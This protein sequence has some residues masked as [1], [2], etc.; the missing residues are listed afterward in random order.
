MVPLGN[1]PR[2]AGNG[3]MAFADAWR[4]VVVADFRGPLAT[5]DAGANW[6][7]L[8]LNKPV[9][10]LSVDGD[11]IVI[12]IQSKSFTLDAT[13][14]V[15]PY[16]PSSGKALAKD[17]S[18]GRSIG[19]HALRMA[20]D[21]GVP[22]AKDRALVAF[23]GKLIEV[24]TTDGTVVRV[25]KDVYPER[26]SKCQGIPLG[27]GVGF[28]CGA[29]QGSTVV[30]QYEPPDFLRPVLSYPEPKVVLSS[31]N[32]AIVVR[33]PCPKGKPIAYQSQYCVRSV[34]G[35]HREVRFQGDLG[36]ER[37]VALADGRVAVLIAPRPGAEARL[38]LLDGSQASA[39]TLSFDSLSKR[40]RALAEQGLWM[41][42]VIEVEPGVLGVWVEA[43]GPVLGMHIDLE[44]N[45]KAGPLQTTPGV[46]LLSGRLGLVWRRG[47]GWETTDGGLRWRE[48][49]APFS[50]RKK[51]NGRRGCSAIGCAVEGWLR[52]GWGKPKNKDEFKEAP[53]SKVARPAYHPPQRLRFQCAATGQTSAPPLPIPKTQIVQ[54]HVRPP[55]RI[56]A[57]QGWY[58]FGSSP[59][60]TLSADQVGVSSGRDYGGLMFRTYAWGPKAADWSQTGRWVV[61]FDDPF[62]LGP[63]VTTLRS[64]SPWQDFTLAAMNSNQVRA[65]LLDPGGRSAVLVWCSSHNR[66]DVFGL[67]EGMV[68]VHFKSN[69][70]MPLI[71]S[72][73]R[74]DDGW[75]LLSGQDSLSISVY[76]V[77]SNGYVRLIGSY[78][79][80]RK[81]RH[82]K[83]EL[84]RRATGHGVALW[85]QPSGKSNRLVLPIDTTTGELGTVQ[86]M[87]RADLD[88]VVPPLCL[89][90]QDGWLVDEEL[91]IT[92][93]FRLPNGSNF[94]R[95]ARVR[96]RV[97]AGQSCLEV[98]AAH[99]KAS[100][101]Q[102]SR[103]ASQ[104]DV[105]GQI[106]MVIWDYS[107]QRKYELKCAP[108][109]RKPS[110]R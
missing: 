40:Q 101:I 98:I 94:G 19:Q 39:K 36:A 31:G 42:G 74:A 72:A 56:Q 32:G 1:L 49:V 65:A 70:P 34:N 103:R 28:V 38:V 66:C 73:V 18:T 100:E 105:R 80:V 95:R 20:V 54:A 69:K 96:M 82:D 46:I 67:T 86:D 51:T 104:L 44:G 7:P 52:V 75:Y 68:P 63:P 3:P 83:L 89:A 84:V 93:S 110:N 59:A 13:G 17:S 41:H 30:F 90:G 92:P 21:R 77:N 10:E 11:L 37:V 25:V 106:P 76:G 85:F 14:R 16:E 26:L 97:S 64:A 91:P 43:G 55:S 102:S 24:L 8:G 6:I 35:L 58:P 2:L 62:D 71:S 60:P 61:R 87:G 47:E 22:I 4:G 78:P 57:T 9:T 27:R 81:N 45:V 50:I 15:A 109:E 79:R 33:A 29:E 108:R 48:F 5:F 12:K 107:A 88:G 23:E 99:A 53:T